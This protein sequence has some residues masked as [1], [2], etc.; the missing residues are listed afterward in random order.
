MHFVSDILGYQTMKGRN[1][2]WNLIS[3]LIFSPKDINKSIILKH[4]QNLS[5]QLVE[6]NLVFALVHLAQITVIATWEKC[7]PERA[8]YVR[9][10][11]A[12]NVWIWMT[13]THIVTKEP[14]MD[15]VNRVINLIDKEWRFIVQDLVVKKMNFTGKFSLFTDFPSF[16][17]TD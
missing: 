4:V 9:A 12:R 1:F 6:T 14:R 17:Q 13:V 7:V 10:P 11:K 5:F 15:I 16:W 8:V 2:L 3:I